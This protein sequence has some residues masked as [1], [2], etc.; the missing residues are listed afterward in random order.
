MGRWQGEY[1]RAEAVIVARTFEEKG[2]GA[3]RV[4]G[5]G[6]R[7]TVCVMVAG[8]GPGKIMAVIT[9]EDRLWR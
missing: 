1:G 7:M 5:G 3:V 2:L 9:R 4:D 8:E 6:S